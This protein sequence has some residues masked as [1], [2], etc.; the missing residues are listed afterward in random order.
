MNTYTV[1]CINED[2]SEY[3]TPVMMKSEFPLGLTVCGGC[4]QP[5]VNSA[6]ITVDTVPADTVTSTKKK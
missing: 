2:C 3:S 4:D 5:M 1:T 6:P